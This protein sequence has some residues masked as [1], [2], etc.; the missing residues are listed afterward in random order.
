VGLT[1]GQNSANNNFGYVYTGSIAGTVY[2][3]SNHNGTLDSGEPGIGGVTV[4]LS[5]GGSTVATTTTAANGTY[6]FSNL[7]PGS[8]S[9][10]TPGTA[11]SE[12]LETASPL[13]VGLTAGQ[14]SANNNFGYVTG[15]I[16]GTV[17]T[18]SNR[19]GVLN[20]GEPDIAGVTVTLKNAS[21]V[22]VATTT[23]G[24]NGAYSFT[25]LVAGSY[26]VS[27]PAT[28]SSETLETAGSLSIVLTAGQSSS[29]DNF[30]YVPSALT[31][32]CPTGTTAVVGTSYSS[33]AVAA[34]GVLPYTFS[35]IGTLPPGLNLN[36]STGVV[37][38]TPTTAGTYLFSIKV[39][40]AAGQTAISSCT[41]AC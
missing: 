26:T 39:T 20:T 13:S 41:S 6:S 35:L 17:Y 27:V 4:T 14:N 5:L 7:A 38:G 22:V 12:N 33:P 34:G 28:A 24:S 40:D 18:D 32:A 9:I 2:T 15:S 8:Y 37:Y 19:N 16:S 23:S 1:A 29:G 31:L 30:G 3:D 11:G 25:G 36:T 21:N 10:S